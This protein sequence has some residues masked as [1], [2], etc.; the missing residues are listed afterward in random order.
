MPLNPFM[1]SEAKS[2]VQQMVDLGVLEECNEPANSTIFIVQKSSGKWRL[3]CD[4]KGYNK[5]IV[6]YV[7]HL[8][9]PYELINKICTFRMFSYMD[10]SDAYFQVPLSEKSLKENCGFRFRYAV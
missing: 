4:L 3:I 6:D 9:S 1:Q 7:V 10:F 5:Q 2:L 8:P